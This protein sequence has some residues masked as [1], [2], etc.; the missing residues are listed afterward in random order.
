VSVNKV[1]TEMD[2]P[3]LGGVAHHLLRPGMYCTDTKSFG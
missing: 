2:V 3:M 1:T